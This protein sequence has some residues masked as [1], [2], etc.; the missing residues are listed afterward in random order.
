M[1]AS[2]TK[3]PEV[4]PPF[5]WGGLLGYRGLRRPVP[6]RG[7]VALNHDPKRSWAGWHFGWQFG[8]SRGTGADPRPA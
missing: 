3:R 1:V 8:G 2:L 7:V 4:G 5:G 6:E